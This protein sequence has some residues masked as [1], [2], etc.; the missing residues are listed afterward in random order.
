MQY[1]LIVQ[2]LEKYRKECHILQSEM[3]DYLD[4]T[5][6]QYSKLE[7]GRVKLSHEILK[8]LDAHGCNVDLMITGKEAEAIL[9]SLEKVYEESSAE[10]FY[11]WLGL[12]YW[13]VNRGKYGKREEERIGI[14]L[15]R[16][17]TNGDKKMTPLERLRKAYGVSQQQMADIIGVNIKK[18]RDL[19]KGK[20]QLDAELMANIY[21]VTKC[22]PSYFMNERGYY[23]SV[24]SEE[25][26]YHTEKEDMLKVLLSAQK[27]IDEIAKGKKK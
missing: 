1:D 2:K 14:K 25:C 27:E 4:I 17:F 23:L 21:E 6:S 16:L 26:R 19:E 10:G 24:I 3:A 13:L 12:C 22:R 15:L 20:L 7:L 9:P 18:Y 5:Q 8:K 11:D